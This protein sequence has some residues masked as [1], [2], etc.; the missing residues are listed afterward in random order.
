MSTSEYWRAGKEHTQKKPLVATFVIDHIL[1]NSSAK[2]AKIVPAVEDG[3][4]KYAKS[5]TGRKYLFN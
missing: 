2:M 1:L 5:D 4:S 3:A